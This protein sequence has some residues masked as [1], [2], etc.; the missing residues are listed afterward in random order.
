M[1]RIMHALLIC[2]AF[3]PSASA[4]NATIAECCGQEP[5][6]KKYYTGR[7]A[8][9]SERLKAIHAASW[10]KH[11]QHIVMLSARAV[12]DAYDAESF[13][14]VPAI[15]D[16]SSCGSCHN[17]SACGVA[18]CA[19]IKAGNWKAGADGYSEQWM[20]DCKNTGGC[21]GGWEWDDCKLLMAGGPL[22]SDYGPYKARAGSCKTVK[23]TYKI[24]DMGMCSQADGVAKTA[25][26]QACIV[27]YG[28]ISIAVAADN[29]FA[30]YNGGLFNGSGSISINHAVMIV[31]WKTVNGVVYWKLRNSW[32]TGWGEN[33]YMWIRAG[34][35]Q[36]GDSAF[37]CKAESVSPP[38]PPVPPTPPVPPGPAT[39]ARIV[40]QIPGMAD[41][42]LPFTV[43]SAKR[44]NDE[45]PQEVIDALNKAFPPAKKTS[46]LSDK[47]IVDALMAASK[48]TI[49]AMFV[50]L[51]KRIESRFESR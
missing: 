35:N 23:T 46:S 50:V 31:G 20:L 11:G 15:K 32:G 10:A 25:D 51:E 5:E 7:K 4:Q 2:L 30:N 8:P 39:Q 45:V 9:D 26:M 41:Q 6:A 28:P 1:K 48:P 13:G 19:Q 33:G 27:Q 16:Q 22:M 42:V 44:I 49:D 47:Q 3:L 38:V 29:A 40:I 18:T 24:L 34:A 21:D 14:L 36:V 12:P 37:W 17:F 43:P